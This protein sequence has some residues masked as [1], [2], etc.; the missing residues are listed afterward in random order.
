M[1]INIISSTDSDH[2]YKVYLQP[3]IHTHVHHTFSYH[4]RIRRR[5]K[6]PN[7]EMPLADPHNLRIEQAYPYEYQLR[8]AR[9]N[10]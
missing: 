2:R 3:Y 1:N 8:M 7:L 4:N 5:G 9:D 6:E 10:I